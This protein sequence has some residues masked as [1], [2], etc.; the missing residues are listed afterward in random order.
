V[1]TEPGRSFKL[2][3]AVEFQLH[4]VVVVQIVQADNLVASL[5]QLFGNMIADE[6]GGACYKNFSHY[7]YSLIINLAGNR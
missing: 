4:I 5:Q 6:T 7:R 3:E 2:L 1:E